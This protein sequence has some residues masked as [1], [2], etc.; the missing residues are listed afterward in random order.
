MEGRGDQIAEPMEGKMAE[1]LRSGSVATKLQRIAEL[2]RQRS[3]EALTSVAHVID[4]E[5][6][7]EA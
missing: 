5:W 7:T 6:M 3:G 4:L 2:S 1:T